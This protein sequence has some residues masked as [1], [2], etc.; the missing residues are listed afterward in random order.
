M[1]E[2]DYYG[3]VPCLPTIPP[4]EGYNTKRH[5]YLETVLSILTVPAKS[6]N[7]KNTP[8]C[9]ETLRHIRT[10]PFKRFWY[11]PYAPRFEYC[12]GVSVN[13]L[14]KVMTGKVRTL[15]LG[16]NAAETETQL[17][18]EPP[19]TKERPPFE[20]QKQCVPRS[21]S[22]CCE[23]WC[24]PQH[25]SRSASSGHLLPE[26]PTVSIS[27]RATHKGGI[28]KMLIP[29]RKEAKIKRQKP[30]KTRANR[31]FSEFT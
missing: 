20:I 5:M 24:T 23:I 18:A 19:L 25:P 17:S 8:P 1:K 30:K 4:G 26:S 27:R 14:E 28:W 2:S 10:T 16:K 22:S 7:N 12:I 9:I 15:A 13:K 21:I 29:L 3:L 6:C 31:T 11:L